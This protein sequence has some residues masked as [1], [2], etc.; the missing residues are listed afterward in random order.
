MTLSLKTEN[1]SYLFW[2]FIGLETSG[3]ICARAEKFVFNAF[4]SSILVIIFDHKYVLFELS[5]I[6]AKY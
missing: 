6:E 4:L 5:N 3:F 2:S 1:S